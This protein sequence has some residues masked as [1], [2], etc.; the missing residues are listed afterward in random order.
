MS[1][2]K[3]SY[4]MIT[5]APVNI[6]DYG[7]KGDG[8]TDDTAAIQ[9]AL[10]AVIANKAGIMYV[11]AG[12]YKIT[13]T[14]TF[15]KCPPL[16]VQGAAGAINNIGSAADTAGVSTFLNSTGG[17]TMFVLKNTITAGQEVSASITFIDVGFQNAGASNV[18]VD[19][20][21][22]YDKTTFIRCSFMGGN[23][24]Y[25]NTS[26]FDVLFDSCYFDGAYY[27]YYQTGGADS[28][29]MV[30]RDC[31]FRYCTVGIYATA[32]N[33]FYL[34]N[35]LIE[36]TATG[37]YGIY[38]DNVFHLKLDGCHF[39]QNG[40][41][42]DVKILGSSLQPKFCVVIGCTFSRDSVNAQAI[43]FAIY[44]TQEMVFVGNAF[45]GSG[46][47]NSLSINT[48]GGRNFTGIGN[49]YGSPL[50]IYGA[51]D[52]SVYENTYTPVW[53]ATGTA[54][55]LGNGTITGAYT[56]VGNM[57]TVYVVLTMGSTTTYGTGNYHVTL[58]FTVAKTSLGVAQGYNLGV[59]NEIFF[60]YA[61]A[62]GNYVQFF[63]SS[64]TLVG[65]LVPH[66]W[67]SGDQ[68]EFSITF[69]AVNP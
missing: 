19:D 13:S 28:L 40:P 50:S 47:T 61:P 35:C 63:T 57:V 56:K 59:G 49:V 20:Q 39:E 17:S 62:T 37:G 5:G 24:A 9:A 45:N 1:L 3:V 52:L 10:A 29:N 66:T 51:A 68:I 12:T 14:I 38:V 23:K 42:P 7:A 31:I 15:D 21:K 53:S 11:P 41:N 46:A 6:L 25:L 18:A 65:Q 43:Q 36:S 44:E 32:G 22:G 58:P 64:N 34:T 27:G 69:S 2:T 67:K 33:S 55:S 4:S 48:G 54:V 26:A 30:W 16:V 8:S 60:P